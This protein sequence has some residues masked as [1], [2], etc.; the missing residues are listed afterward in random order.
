MEEVM[1]D[2]S[3]RGDNENNS[4]FDDGWVSKN[5]ILQ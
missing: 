1:T 4:N 5:C 2:K 3:N